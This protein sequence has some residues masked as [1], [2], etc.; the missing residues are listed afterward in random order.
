MQAS[1]TVVSADRGALDLAQPDCLASRLEEM[2][3]DLIINC[4]AYTAVDRAEDERALAQTINAE[5]PGA[6]AQ[7]AAKNCVPF[8]HF[9]TDYVFDGSGERPWRE[10][11]ATRPL[12]I[13]G[14]TKLAGE[15]RVRAAA[16]S[17]LILRT[18]WVYASWGTNFLCKITELARSQK[19]LRVV[20][21]QIGAPTS[22][23]LIADVVTKIVGSDLESLRSRA[24]QAQGVIHLCASGETSWYLFATAIVNGLRAR[25]VPLAIERVLPIRSEERPT[26][27]RRPLNSQLD[28]ARLSGLFG[29]TP[30]DWRA[31]L[32]PELDA[33]AEGFTSLADG[34]GAQP[35]A[36]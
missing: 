19:E 10:D 23:A 11:D 4:A 29:I 25:R 9:S 6:M 31:A 36:P 22:A 17:F 30:A 13:Y 12:S 35:P 26:R 7:W 33:L 5:A 3:P 32:E 15:Q 14:S 1:A 2:A 18:S 27:A 28:L 24:A 21:D 8:I 20:A 16:G 34:A